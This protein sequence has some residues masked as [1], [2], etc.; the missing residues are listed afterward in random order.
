MESSPSSRHRVLD[1]LLRQDEP[2][3]RPRIATAC[4]VSRPTVFSAVQHLEHAGLIQETGQRSGSPGRSATLFEVAPGVGTVLAIDIGG[5][6]VRVAVADIRG[7]SLAEVREPTALPGG[8]AI[9]AQATDLARKALASAGLA[10]SSLH[11]VTVSVPGVV[12]ADGGTVH[13][14][15]NIDQSDP[16]DFRTP[17]REALSAP[18]RLENNVHLAALGERWRGVGRNLDTFVIVSI[19]AGIGA[20]VVHD[21]RL[22][23]GSHG[24][25]GEV[26]FL[27]TPRSQPHLDA[28]AHDEA[29][30]LSLLTAALRHPGWTDTPPSTVEE[31]FLRA[32][33]GEEPAAELVEEECVRVAAVIASISA[34]IDPEAVILTGGVGANDHLME[35]SRQ[36]AS[37]MTLYPPVVIRSELGERAS[38]VGGVYL[39]TRA[40]RNMVMQ[41]L[42]R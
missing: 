22:I 34:I 6:N 39:G 42:D 35:R 38:V 2:V 37:E 10:Q 30:G 18:V 4:G 16:F 5:S 28:R 26:A 25:S 11:A 17:I 40:A 36:L 31:L 33:S 14:A 27:P 23:R 29:G 32:A 13:F 15:S 8:P 20:G 19:G 41:S 3:T 21:G 9:V 7:R 1:F 12:D 24:A